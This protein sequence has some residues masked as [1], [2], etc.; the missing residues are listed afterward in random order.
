MTQRKP[1]LDVI[2]TIAIMVVMIT[3]MFNY[4]GVLSNNLQSVRWTLLLFLKF[5]TII[6][7]PLFLLLTGFLQSK[8]ELNAKHYTSIIPVM[9]SYFVISF[10]SS[11]TEGFVSETEVF[12]R[13]VS[14]FDFEY[15]YAWYVEMYIGL[16]LII[17]FLNILYKSLSKKNKIVLISILSCMTFLPASLQYVSFF[18]SGFEILPDF[19]VNLYVVAYF[20]IGSYIA[21]YKPNPKKLLCFGVLMLTAVLETV[22]GFIFSKEAYAWWLFNNVAS[23]THAV[24]AVSMFL[25]FYNINIK[26]KVVLFVTK[27]ISACSFE[28]YLISYLT[29]NFCYRYLH[30]SIP[31]ILIIDF[32][33]AFTLANII[34]FVLNPVS[35][36]IKKCILN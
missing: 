36:A 1:G 9:L 34:R 26:N 17:P 22:L 11:V 13:I 32:A 7:V 28:M 4:T 35:K 25:M 21:E 12:S 2:R 18:G 6:G 20:F 5:V 31:L 33:M 29:D 3:H 24:L 23:V 27:A 14:I 30:L 16:F 19:F 15:G 10:I 8:R